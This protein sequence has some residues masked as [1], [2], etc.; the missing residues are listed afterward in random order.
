MDFNDIKTRLQ[1][2]YNSINAIYDTDIEGGINVEI[3][4]TSDG[5]S[6]KTTFGRNDETEA[7]VKIISIIHNIANLKDNLK[8]RLRD[9]R[10]NPQLVEAEINNSLPLQLIADLSNQDKH[11][12]PLERTQRSNKDPLIKNIKSGLQLSTGAEAGSVAGFRMMPDGTFQILSAH[13]I[14]VDI[15]I[16][17][18][19]LIFKYL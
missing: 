12:Y 17:F 7:Q 5:I 18:K 16:S 2:V 13:A 6:M 14:S 3:R 15:K 10:L 9:L 1:R 4:E 11:G 8:N 19:T